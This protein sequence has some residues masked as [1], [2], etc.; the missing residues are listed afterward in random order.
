M[1]VRTLGV[2][3][4]T[5]GTPVRVTATRLPCQAFMVQAHPGNTDIGAVGNSTIVYATDTGIFGW[6]G[7][8]SSN[9]VVI[10]AFST[11]HSFA[12]GA[13]NMADVWLDCANGT[14]KFVVSIVE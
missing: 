11:R 2:L 4:V 5:A 10:P 7:V 14:Q 9:K 12:P 6:V 8:P 1:A 3:S 13:F